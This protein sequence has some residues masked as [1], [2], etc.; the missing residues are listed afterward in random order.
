M[1]EIVWSSRLATGIDFVDAQHRALIDAFRFLEIYVR[2]HFRDEESEM[3]RL[4]CPEADLN[5]RGHARFL[6][7]FEVLSTRLRTNGPSEALAQEVHHELG[8]WF[9]HHIMLIDIRMAKTLE[10]NRAS[11]HPG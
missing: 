3:D 10:D 4:H 9:V 8:E 11:S 2:E 7:S 1:D 6:A 5:R